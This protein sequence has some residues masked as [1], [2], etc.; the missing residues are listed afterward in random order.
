MDAL[1]RDLEG[2]S[3]EDPVSGM[4]KYREVAI[5]LCIQMSRYSSVAVT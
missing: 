2:K 1:I 5:R 4:S 3:E